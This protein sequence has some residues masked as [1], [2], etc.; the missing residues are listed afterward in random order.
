MADLFSLTS[1]LMIKSPHGGKKV[2]A[3]LF[4][5]PQGIVFFEVFWNLMDVNEGVHFIAGEIKG[6][7]PWKVGEYVIHVLGCQGTDPELAEDFSQW[8][9]Y[10]QTPMNAYPE[11]DEIREFAKSFA[12]SL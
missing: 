4:R 11:P 8:Q 6:E 3:E 9:S 5:H 7:G 12:G 1:P 2:I 10:L